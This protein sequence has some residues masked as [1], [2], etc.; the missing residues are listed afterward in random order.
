MSEPIP[1]VFTAVE[2]TLKPLNTP[3]DFAACGVEEDTLAYW[4][5]QGIGPAWVKFG[6]SVL[7]AKEDILECLRAH[8]YHSTAEYTQ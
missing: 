6:K 8:R 3:K 7:Y 1:P 2:E 4:R 5:T